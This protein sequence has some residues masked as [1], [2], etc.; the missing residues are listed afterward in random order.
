M[1]FAYCVFCNGILSMVFLDEEKAS[2]Y[3]EMKNLENAE[4]GRLHYTYETVYLNED[5]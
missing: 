4:T 5:V 2:Q 1:K 3:I